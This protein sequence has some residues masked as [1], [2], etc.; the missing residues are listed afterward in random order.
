MYKVYCDPE[1]KSVMLTQPTV[2][3][4]TYQCS[5]ETYKEQIEKLREENTYLKNKV[6]K[7]ICCTSLVYVLLEYI[8]LDAIN[9]VLKSYNSICIQRI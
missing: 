4:T 9:F 6:I 1:G 2:N 3:F 8:K 5:E 7:L